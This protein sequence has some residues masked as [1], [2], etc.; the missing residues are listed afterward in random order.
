MEMTT[1]D[2]IASKDAQLKRLRKEKRHWKQLSK[3]QDQLLM[4]YRLGRSPAQGVIEKATAARRKL[5][6]LQEILSQFQYYHQCQ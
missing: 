2:I 5:K 4:A 1:T 3:A 6:E